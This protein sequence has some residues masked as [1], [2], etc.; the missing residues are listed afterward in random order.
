MSAVYLTGVT[1]PKV[2]A[3][4]TAE[5]WAGLH[6]LL[7]QPESYGGTEVERWPRWAADNGCF[8]KGDA[9][10]APAWLGWLAALAPGSRSR[11]LFAVAP[12]VVGDAAATLKRSTPYLGPIRAMGYP[13]AYV[14]QDGAELD[15]GR[16]PWAGL[17]V[18]FLGGSTEWKLDPEGAGR[19]TRAAL[20][21]GKTVHMGRVNSRKRLRLA[22]SWGCDSADGTFL[23][24]GPNV[25]L[26]KLLSWRAQGDLFAL[27]GGDA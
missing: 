15:L 6:G 16:I 5:P 25:N 20:E 3:K 11:C 12:D 26:P 23:A 17:D 8:S 4:L 19:V 24:F 27:G 2:T 1:N 7:V 21:R 9:F 13:V 14:G 10:D 18:L 22:E